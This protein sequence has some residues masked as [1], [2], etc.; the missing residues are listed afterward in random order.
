M[1]IRLY[2]LLL[3]VVAGG[4]GLPIGDCATSRR[5]AAAERPNILFIFADDQPYRTIGC[6]PET[7]AWVRTP[8]IDALAETGV[9]FERAYLGAWCM[10][11]RA[12]LLTGKLQSGV[13][14]MRM[15]GPYPAS[16]YDPQ[17]C[18]FW[19]AALRQHGYHT[20]QIGKWH[21]GVDTGFGRDWD[22]QVVWNRPGQPDNAGA[23]YTDQVLAING[24]VQPTP[25]PGYSTDNYTLWAEEYIRGQHRTAD[26]PW[27]LWL[28]Y[29]AIHGPTTPAARH[30]GAYAGQ[31]APVPADIFGPRPDKPAYLEITQAWVSDAQGRPAKLGKA[32][33]ATN[34]DH[35]VPGM[36]L[37]AWLQQVNECNLAV[38][39]GVGRLVT[40]LRESGQYDNTLVVYTADQGFAHG[41][42]GCSIKVAPYDAN[43]A[44]ALIVAMP[45]Q[46]PQGAVCPVPVNGAD[47][48]STLLGFAGL[49]EPWEMHGRDMRPL[50]DHPADK[51]TDAAWQRPTLLMHTAD[52]YGADTAEIPTDY[53]ELTHTGDVPWWV[54]IR[55]GQYKYIR[56]LLAGEME[57][58]YDLAADPEE[59]VNL[60]RQP[61]QQDLTLRLRSRAVEELR[62]IKAPF[63]DT[64][65][66]VMDLPAQ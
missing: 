5:V 15:E 64:M 17:R 23:Y 19:P 24:V 20:A 54:L 57:E 10:P 12:T 28:C 31:S 56:N 45:T 47:L 22:Y 55:D 16:T 25:D 18:P 4:L 7:P 39:E 13:Q 43:I 50:L 6:Y 60:A 29:G 30:V 61:G 9:R 42:H 1:P 38:D 59:L 14:T 11:S 53:A 34:F 63:T 62:R 66:P 32:R 51:P 65:P 37:D 58:V 27:F 46:L 40:A 8:H 2:P 33:K 26:Q 35:N 49:P 41:E 21:T 36:P 48:T 52:H 44:S 3:V